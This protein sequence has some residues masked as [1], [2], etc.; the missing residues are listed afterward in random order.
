MN[1]K[2]ITLAALAA[3]LS[4]PLAAQE[5]DAPDYGWSGKG[6]FGLVSTSGNTDTQSIN[7]A[8]EFIYNSEKWRHRLAASAINAEDDGDTTA[9][10]F[11]FGAQTDYKLSER[12]YVFGALRYEKDDFSAYEDQSTLTFGYGRQLLDN[13]IH[14]LKIEGG[15]G[16]RTAKLQETGESE[17]DAIA[18]GLVDWVWQLT[19]STDLT[20]RFLVES[21]SDNTFIQ[22][23]LGLAVSINSR[24]ALKLGFQVRHNTDVEDGVDKTDTLTSANLVYK[25]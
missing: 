10:R 24:F 9:K 20:E 16:Y 11:D 23:D 6:E 12:S 21:G 17:S 13:D 3:T 8:L 14:Q 19:P 15:L 22:N 2:L 5:E 18:R 25:F 4:S 7:L 1:S